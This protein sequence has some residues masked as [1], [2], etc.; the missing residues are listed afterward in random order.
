MG[1][2]E[3]LRKFSKFPHLLLALSCETLLRNCRFSTERLEGLGLMSC[4]SVTGLS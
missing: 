3:N 4:L 2:K 1:S